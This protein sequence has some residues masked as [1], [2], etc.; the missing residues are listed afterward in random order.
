[1]K[2]LKKIQRILNQLQFFL[3]QSCLAHLKHFNISKIKSI[4]L[5]NMQLQFLII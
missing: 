4:N 3:E 1:M 5:N 2:D